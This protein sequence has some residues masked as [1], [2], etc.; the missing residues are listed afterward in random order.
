MDTLRRVPA[1][2]CLAGG[3]LVAAVCS[4]QVAPQLTALSLTSAN[5]LSAGADVSYDYA[6]TAGTNPVSGISITLIDAQG[7]LNVL[8]MVG[9][10][11]SV[12]TPTSS[13]LLNGNYTIYEII[14]GDS[15]NIQTDYSN[16]GSITYPNGGTGPATS[17]ISFSPL[18]FTLMGAPYSSI[19]SP[20]LTSFTLSSS[21][22]LIAGADVTY[23]Y[24]I[25]P[26]TLGL[27]G[28]ITVTLFDPTGS[29][30]GM[31]GSISPTGA[32]TLTLTS[33]NTWLNGS[34][35]VGQIYITDGYGDE[36]YLPTTSN[37]FYERGGMGPPTQ[38]ISFPSLGFTLSSGVAP[39]PTPTPSLTP[40]PTPTP[41]GGSAP[42]PTPTPAPTLEVTPTPTPLTAR[43][44][45]RLIN[46]STRAQVGTGGNILIPGFFISGSGTETLLI[47]ADGPALTQFS[48]G[49]VL[50]QPSLSVIDSTGRVIAT[51]TGWGTNMNPGLIASTSATVGAFA[52]AQDSADCALIVSLPAGA[53]TAQVTGVNNTTGVALAEVYE[54]SSTGTRLVNI[55]TRAQVGTGPNLLIPGFVVSGSGS[56]ELLVRADGPGL[57]QFSVSG[58]LAQPSLSVFDNS[59][60]VVATNTGWGSAPNAAQ[61]ASIGA[62]VG[63][64]ALSTGSSD[65]AQIVSLTPGS[66]TIQVSGAGNSTGVA[67]AEVYEVPQY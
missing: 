20:L 28:S 49:G 27:T 31:T 9:A 51:N 34:Y 1:A 65:S 46:L 26:G 5:P 32:G 40:T 17:S 16:S 54:V 62:A 66:Y 52:L 23:S 14:V 13:L 57:A 18:E 63:A 47:R 45:A 6:I 53:Y 38:S 12:Y 42:T 8:S 22:N 35:T 29:P 43:P 30:Y 37:I 21:P 55:S 15:S 48:V 61:I 39:T 59:A 10:S 2:A 67:L 44:S 24:A 58:V 11:G 60:D 19:T 7:H 25:T 56:E 64:F 36:T 50:A 4:A 41:T 33:N 3:L